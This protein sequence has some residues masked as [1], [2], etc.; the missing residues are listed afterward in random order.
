V[1]QLTEKRSCAG[2]PWW[3][4]S[5]GMGATCGSTVKKKTTLGIKRKGSKKTYKRGGEKETRSFGGAWESKTISTEIKAC[6]EYYPRVTSNERKPPIQSN[7]KNEV[8]IYES[9]RANGYSSYQKCR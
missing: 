3:T 5:E 9:E 6:D 8:M 7:L 2:I 1:T 4:T